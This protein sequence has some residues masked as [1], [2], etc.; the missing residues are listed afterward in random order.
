MRGASGGNGRFL[1]PLC[2]WLFD[3]EGQASLESN[4]STKGTTLGRTNYKG[5]CANLE[6]EASLELVQIY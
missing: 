6:E 3:R 4:W 2:P 1:S 5:G